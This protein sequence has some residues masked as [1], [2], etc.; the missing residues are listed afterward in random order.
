MTDRDGMDVLPGR[1][2]E[3]DGY[4]SA[5]AGRS[6]LKG[7]VHRGIG[8]ATLLGMRHNPKLTMKVLTKGYRALNWLNAAKTWAK[9]ILRF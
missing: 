3:A 5:R 2:S 7:F 8:N 9:A 1:G 4:R 6:A